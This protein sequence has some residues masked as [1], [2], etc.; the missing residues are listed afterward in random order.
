MLLT[1]FIASSCIEPDLKAGNKAGALRALTKMLFRRRRLEG[2]TA[3]LNQILS[4]ESIESTGIGRGIA[5]PHA[6]AAGLEDLVC[7]VG[8]VSGGLDFNAVDKQPVHLIFLIC[9]PPARQTTYLNFIASVAKLLRGDDAL[10]AILDAG[11]AQPWSSRRSSSRARRRPPLR[12]QRRT[13]D[14]TR[15]C[16]FWLAWSSAPRC[17]NP[18][19]P[20]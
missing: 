1:K 5:V 12:R 9:Y 2:E 8:R 16:F 19:A 6:R 14:S 15:I 13:K 4:R 17:S 7:A 20:G 18:P 10:Q 11:S 3:V